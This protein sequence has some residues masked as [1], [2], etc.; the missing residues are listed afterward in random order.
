L[1]LPA[2]TRLSHGGAAVVL[3][4]VTAALAA[5]PVLRV[6]A[7]HLFTAPVRVTGWRC[8]LGPDAVPHRRALVLYDTQR[9]DGGYGAQQGVLAANFVSHFAS[10][11]RQPVRTYRRG[12]IKRYAAAVYV[13]AD[14]GERLPRAFLADVRAGVRPVMWLGANARQLTDTAFARRFGWRLGADAVGHYRYVRYRGA[15]LTIS[16]DDLTGIHLVRPHRVALL[17][18]AVTAA[19]RSVPWAVRSEKLTY[20]SEAP[21]QDG[22]LTDRSFAVADMMA[23]LFG[24]VRQR[25]R[26]LI[27]LEDVGP[28][29][30]PGQLRAIATMLAARKVPFTIALY[31]LYLGPV[32]QHPRERVPLTA[33]P[34]VIQ[35]LKYALSKGGTLIL[36]GYTHQ[37][38]DLRNPNNGQSGM[39]D[40]FLRV[41]YP[42]YGVLA[43]DNPP[44][45]P[46]PM[47]WTRHRI[48]L[49]LAGVRA[50]GLP[51]PEL[52]EFPEYGA[53]PSEYRV[54][55]SM[56]VARYERT[57]YAAGPPGHPGLQTLTEQSPPYLVRDSY[58]GPVLPETLGFVKGPHV[59]ASGPG[60]IPAV[61]AAAG[62]QKQA[63][64]D[65]VGSVYYHPYLGMAPLRRLVDG[66]RREG[67]Q[68]VSACA[69][70][71]GD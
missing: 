48:D 63:V 44:T 22:T 10:P 28:M 31:P 33:R 55:A 12:E 71:K 2:S 16:N 13:G 18:T 34:Q 46:D 38:G 37:L 32:H 59:P 7:K 20:V 66:M 23:G 50:A 40:E 60:S 30:A 29:A 61:L 14:S 9:G 5:Q 57:S 35:A 8:R 43:F 3:V 70:L 69:V 15:R 26:A 17:G 19:Q 11:V 68:F 27:R 53:S 65:N 54:A 21:L 4:V 25:H 36:H 51:R 45:P 47:A 24:D 56:F 58:G 41:H 1:T 42:S 67:Y 64:R 39:D 52:W 49:A 6:A 62:M